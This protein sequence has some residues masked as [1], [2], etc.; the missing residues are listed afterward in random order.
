MW[1]IWV[2]EE[3][4]SCSLVKKKKSS[5][6]DQICR[7]AQTC[8]SHIAELIKELSNYLWER[9]SICL[10]HPIY[11]HVTS[12]EAY[13]P[14]FEELSFWSTITF[15]ISRVVKPKT[16]AGGAISMSESIEDLPKDWF[17]MC[18]TWVPHRGLPETQQPNINNGGAPVRLQIRRKNK[19]KTLL[20]ISRWISIY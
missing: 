19:K 6:S 12:I 9:S 15:W 8:Q 10:C 5:W 14:E 13:T 17:F 2:S 3:T 7:Y 16:N 11:N 4:K 20:A 1:S 18:A